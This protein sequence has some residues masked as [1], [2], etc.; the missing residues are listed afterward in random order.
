M[1][2]KR[3]TSAAAQRSSNRDPRIDAYIAKA[4]EFA[5]P[6]LAHVREVV[7]AG[8]PEI[9]E[10]IKWG[11][12]AFEYHGILAHMA[13]FKSHCVFG[14]WKHELMMGTDARAMEA[15][16]SFGSLRTLKDLPARATLVRYVQQAR[17]LNEEGVK[18]PRT[19]TAA[20]KP[21]AMHPDLAA[22]LQKKDRET[23]MARATLEG[24]APSHR[25]EY[26]EWIQ[27]A[28]RDETRARRIETAIEWLAQGK[29]RNWKYEAS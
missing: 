12:P 3:A 20:K 4:P 13:A 1:P 25:R 18:A 14:F 15:M 2:K 21:I 8:G 16:G 11:M 28:K 24:L 5:R 9:V 23:A 7:H 17:K 27:D 22:A 6:I 29:R 10:T 19:K 26:L